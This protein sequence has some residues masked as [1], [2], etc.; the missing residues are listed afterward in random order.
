MKSMKGMKREFS[1]LSNRVIGCTIEVHRVLGPGVAS[2]RFTVSS[3]EISSHSRADVLQGC[4]PFG[5]TA[6]DRANIEAWPAALPR[7]PA[8]NR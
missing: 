3:S 4:I 1:E 8:C 2:R 7:H 5:I 6:M